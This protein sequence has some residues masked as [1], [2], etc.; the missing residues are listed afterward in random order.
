M[1][2][3]FWVGEDDCELIDHIRQFTAEMEFLRE[4]DGLFEPIGVDTVD[5]LEVKLVRLLLLIGVVLLPSKDQTMVFKLS[6]LPVHEAGQLDD[7]VVIPY[8]IEVSLSRLIDDRI[9]IQS[10]IVLQIPNSWLFR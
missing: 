7:D 6:L 1:I 4:S 10:S 5:L 9:L 2:F 8:E 3:A